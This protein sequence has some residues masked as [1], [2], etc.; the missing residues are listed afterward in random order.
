MHNASTFT[1]PWISNFHIAW[2]LFACSRARVY[3]CA[4]MPD[5][6]NLLRRCKLK[7]TI[8]ESLAPFFVGVL[9]LLGPSITAAQTDCMD[10]GSPLD[11]AAPSQTTPQ[12]LIQRFTAAE[13][14][15]SRIEIHQ[16][17]SYDPVRSNTNP[18][19]HTP[20]KPPT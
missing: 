4:C 13:N 11:S 10:S 7:T 5:L 19:S 6:G 1:L 18:P 3:V 9:L 15:P 14:K 17:A 8:R 2:A 20:R 16:T 12:E